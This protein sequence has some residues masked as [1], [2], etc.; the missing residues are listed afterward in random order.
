MTV[1]AANATSVTGPLRERR[2]AAGVT[3]RQ[4]AA[5][6]ECSETMVR[7]LEGGYRPS[8]GDV[9]GRVARALDALN[10]EDA[11]AEPRLATTSVGL[12]PRH[13]TA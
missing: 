1:N 3:Q 12:D 8:Y 6:A 5:R 4:L 2:L 13:G 9:V 7:V 11:A 10:D